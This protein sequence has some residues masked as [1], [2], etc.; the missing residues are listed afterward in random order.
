MLNAIERMFP[1]LDRG[2]SRLLLTAQQAPDSGSPRG[3]VSRRPGATVIEV[4]PSA[5][6]GDCPVPGALNC[7][8]AEDEQGGARV[9]ALR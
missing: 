3:S 2:L 4:L 9:G 1:R 5:C 8:V 6:S 7:D